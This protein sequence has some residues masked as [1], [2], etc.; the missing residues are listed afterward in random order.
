MLKAIFRFTLDK[1]LYRTVK[2]FHKNR[3]PSRSGSL[4]ICVSRRRKLVRERVFEALGGGEGS[5]LDRIL[6]RVAPPATPSKSCVFLL[7]FAPPLKTPSLDEM[8]YRWYLVHRP[9]SCCPR[10]C[11]WNTPILLAELN[12]QDVVANQNKILAFEK[13]SKTGD[14]ERRIPCGG[15]PCLSTTGL[16]VWTFA[17]MVSCLNNPRPRSELLEYWFPFD[18]KIHFL[19]YFG[20][21]LKALLTK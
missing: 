9:C 19:N 6:L 20:S 18:G 4:D 7:V 13:G 1:L 2:P 3:G 16:F 8:D 21:P 5:T 17:E 15:V 11:L 10:C 12:L 14:L